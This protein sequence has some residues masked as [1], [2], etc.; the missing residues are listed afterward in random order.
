MTSSGKPSN[1]S[2]DGSKGKGCGPVS[3]SSTRIGRYHHHSS[4]LLPPIFLAFHFNSLFLLFFVSFDAISFILASVQSNSLLSMSVCVFL[5][6]FLTVFLFMRVIL[7]NCLSF[8]LSTGLH[9]FLSACLCFSLPLSLSLPISFFLPLSF[10]LSACLYFFLPVF[11]SACLSF[12]LPVFFI[13]PAFLF[14][15]CLSFCLF[16]FTLFRLE[17]FPIWFA[18]DFSFLPPDLVWMPIRKNCWHL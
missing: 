15:I 11:L 6:I 4:F 1:F 17:C 13:L 5:P 9:S 18:L 8:F 16:F 7:F 2:K 10:F 12:C 3:A 14:F